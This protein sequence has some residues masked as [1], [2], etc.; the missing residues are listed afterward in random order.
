[1]PSIRQRDIADALDLSVATVSRSLADD[2]AIGSATRARV[3]EAADRLGYRKIA[4]VPG[5]ETRSTPQ[6]RA[7]QIGVL[8]RTGEDVQSNEQRVN[9]LEGLSAAARQA[10][11]QLVIDT[12]LPGDDERVQCDPALLPL[13]TGPGGPAGL[14]LWQTFAPETLRR[15]A[16]IRPC[17]LVNN[18]YVPDLRLDAIGP[19][20]FDGMASLVSRLY[21]AGHRRIGLVGPLDQHVWGPQRVAGYTQGMLACGLT[22]TVERFVDTNQHPEAISLDQLTK[23]NATAWLATDGITAH[24]LHRTLQDGGFRVPED[25]SIASFQPLHDATGQV[26]HT[27]L[28]PPWRDIGRHALRRLL[29]RIDHPTEPG[30]RVLLDCDFHDAGTLCASPD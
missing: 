29:D 22:P 20:H 15:I 8:L 14:I 21:A 18:N 9:L 17:V 27:G 28:T 23:A 2:P 6:P 19:N 12:L 11:V 26:L 25:I 3:I 30:R 13:L 7:R 1:M 10:G 4:R 24:R 16:G 5:H